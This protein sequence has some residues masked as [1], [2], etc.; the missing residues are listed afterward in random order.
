MVNDIA[1]VTGAS[2]GIGR[3]IAKKLSQSGFFVLAI[4]RNINELQSLI[5]EIYA[6]DGQAEYSATD[7]Q[8]DEQLHELS[9]KISEKK[10]KIGVLVHSAGVAKVGSVKTMSAA[11]W[12]ETINT[13]LTVPFKLTQLCMPHLKENATIFFI[14]SVAGRQTFQDWSAYCAS[15]WGLKAFADSLRQELTG[16]SIKVT[17]VF[18]SSVDTPLQDNLP[19]EW[20]REKML[21]A[22]DVADAMIHC[23]AQSEHVQIKEIDLENLA[24]TF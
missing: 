9:E 17:S 16:Q 19:Y 2:K 8:N 4:A 12:N 7:L 10:A 22:D 21:K 3:S 18:P 11:E 13:N 23:L 14:N 24:G 20:D 1:I 6:A 15:K 5:K